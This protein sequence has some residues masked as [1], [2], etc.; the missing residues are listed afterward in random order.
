MHFWKGFFPPV[1]IIFA[2]EG[3]LSSTAIITICLL[4]SVTCVI[5]HPAMPDSDIFLKDLFTSTDDQF[6]L[7]LFQQDLSI[8]ARINQIQY[9]IALSQLKTH[10]WL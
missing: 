8:T 10:F 7:K 3:P 4:S 1:F 5:Y 2:D 9:R 6:H